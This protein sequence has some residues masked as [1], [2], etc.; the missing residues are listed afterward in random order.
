[1]E[2]TLEQILEDYRP[3]AKKAFESAT[4]AAERK[5][6]QMRA[7]RQRGTGA[8][9]FPIDIS[10]S[11]DDAANKILRPWALENFPL[12]NP[13]ALQFKDTPGNGIYRVQ[14]KDVMYL[15]KIETFSQSTLM[16]I[17]IRNRLGNA[18]GKEMVMY[19]LLSTDYK[20]SRL[21][22]NTNNYQKGDVCIFFGYEET[23]DFPLDF[24][25]QE[26]A[27]IMYGVRSIIN[28]RIDIPDIGNIANVGSGETSNI[29][30]NFSFGYFVDEPLNYS[31]SID[32]L[33]D[34]YYTVRR[35]YGTGERTFQKIIDNYI[36]SMVLVY[37][38]HVKDEDMK[39]LY[40]CF[41][42]ALSK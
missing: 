14:Y 31:S 5:Y 35:A 40:E 38:T 11:A 21:S 30:M 37:R 16:E 32:F 41:V 23:I 25:D 28:A 22:E 33:R 6:D 39:I 27:L 1:M 7:Q 36:H 10:L 8:K 20:P 15:V 19:G 24:S 4:Q 18:V 13:Y 34:K 3:V 42:K 12:I 17:F 2:K 26:M 9:I 29:L